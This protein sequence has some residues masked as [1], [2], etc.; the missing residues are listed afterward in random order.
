MLILLLQYCIHTVPLPYLGPVEF[1]E[2][3]EKEEDRG[4]EVG[5]RRKLH[6]V[7]EVHDEIGR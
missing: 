7:Y 4:L 1:E 2:E 3:E 6:A 5:R